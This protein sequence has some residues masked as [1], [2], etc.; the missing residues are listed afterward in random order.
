MM[1]LLVLSA[2]LPWPVVTHSALLHTTSHLLNHICVASFSTCLYLPLI[3]LLFHMVLALGAGHC[4]LC[5]L[6]HCPAVGGEH[7]LASPSHQAHPH[8]RIGN[9]EA[10]SILRGQLRQSYRVK[11]SE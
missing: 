2:D 9:L 6:L 3:F 4:P 1:T 11:E 10:V 7:A 8:S 5:L